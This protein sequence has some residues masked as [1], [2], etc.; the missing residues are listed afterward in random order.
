[1]I[2]FEGIEMEMIEGLKDS[3]NKYEGIMGSE[4]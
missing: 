2:R 1:V 3:I 4:K